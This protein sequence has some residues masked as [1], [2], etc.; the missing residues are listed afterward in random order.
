MIKLH[1]RIDTSNAAEFE[2]EMMGLVS[3][4]MVLDAAELEYISS[5][6]LRVLLKLRKQLGKPVQILNVSPDVYEIFEVTGFTDLLDV[7]KRLRE[8]SVEGCE[9]IGMGGNGEVYRL[10]AETILKLYNEGTSLEKISLEKKYAT[11]AFKA[12]LPCAISYDTVQCG[13]RYGIVFELLNAVTVGK[14][15]DAD[16]SLIPK[17]GR[18]MGALMKQLHSTE[19]PAG[20]LPKMSDK[21]SEWI[22]Y[23]EEKYLAHEDAELMRSV[24]GAIS[25]KNTLVHG[26]FH[27]GNVMLQG[28][29]LLLIDLDDIS[30][31]NA[32]FDL[33]F[34]YAGHVIAAQSSPESMRH[35]MGMST[36]TGLKMYRYTLEEYLGT[37]DLADHE[38]AMQLLSLFFMILY[39]GKGKDSRNLTPERAEGV[40]SQVLPQ[41]R[42]MAPMIAGV[43]GKY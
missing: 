22:N 9:K 30:T 17:L 33:A 38:Q 14:A 5:A 7:R 8:V 27:E 20:I 18:E 28:E 37:E 23:L 3:P 10:D 32:L 39:L 35:S 29:E 6:G 12:G 34:H 13:N 4:D 25:E 36:E 31:G 43:A 19:V 11:E 16:A 15:V 42:Q 2:K 24:A 41:F 21:V 40:L 26:D 1:G